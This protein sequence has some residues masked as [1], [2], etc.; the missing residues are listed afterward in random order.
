MIGVPDMAEVHRLNHAGY[1][2]SMRKAQQETVAAFTSPAGG[3]STS[4]E[5]GGSAM[6]SA[7]R[8]GTVVGAN[9]NKR[10]RLWMQAAKSL[11]TL[12]RC[13][14]Q[15]TK[16]TAALAI[17]VDLCD[18]LLDNK[19]VTCHVVGWAKAKHLVL[20]FECMGKSEYRVVPGC[21]VP[22]NLVKKLQ[23]TLDR[24]EGAP[25]DGHVLTLADFTAGC[26]TRPRE[27]TAS[28]I[29]E[30]L[31]VEV[32][33]Q[34]ADKGKP[35]FGRAVN[36]GMRDLLVERMFWTERTQSGT[37][38]G[39]EAKKDTIF[40]MRT[41]PAR[42]IVS[43]HV[44]DDVASAALYTSDG[45]C[46]LISL[47][48]LRAYMAEC[49]LLPYRRETISFEGTTQFLDG[50]QAWMRDHT[51]SEERK[52]DREG[53]V[54]TLMAQGLQLAPTTSRATRQRRQAEFVLC[55]GLYTEDTLLWSKAKKC[56][57]GLSGPVCKHPAMSAKMLRTSC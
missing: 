18:H 3:R 11:G 19:Q 4:A 56:R 34:L 15:G 24:N 17:T 44:T 39:G 21:C 53:L 28:A 26:F 12:A 13:R 7:R 10:P 5:G 27:R 33:V 32:H 47:D 52:L 38:V 2:A 57:C 49:E 48:A 25:S 40:H 54:L 41:M 8:P 20:S 16:A 35:L 51:T 22:K 29:V 9:A 30:E 23:N 1:L 6:A 45:V 37:K 31:D 50:M 43:A 36:V 55:N 42:A 14:Y 46:A